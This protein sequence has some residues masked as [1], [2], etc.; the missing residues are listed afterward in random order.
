MEFVFVSFVVFAELVL[1]AFCIAGFII[2]WKKQDAMQAKIEENRTVLKPERIIE[3]F[4]RE[5]G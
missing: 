5:R 3:D 4:C 2:N 1:A